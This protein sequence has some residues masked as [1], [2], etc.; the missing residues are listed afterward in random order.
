MCIL[1]SRN[2]LSSARQE[3]DGTHFVSKRSRRGANDDFQSN[4]EESLN[5]LR[6]GGSRRSSRSVEEEG[7]DGKHRQQT[8]E[9]TVLRI[10]RSHKAVEAA[11]VD[12]RS[13]RSTR[14]RFI[15]GESEEKYSDLK[16]MRKQSSDSET[17]S[18]QEGGSDGEHQDDAE[19]ESQNH[20]I[21]TRSTIKR[22][23]SRH[24][25]EKS[26]PAIASTKRRSARVNYTEKGSDDEEESDDETN[27]QTR[28]SVRLK[29]KSASTKRRSSRRNASDSDQEST[30]GQKDSD[31]DEQHDEHDDDRMSSN[32]RSKRVRLT[33]SSQNDSICS[34]NGKENDVAEFSRKRSLSVTS[35]QGSNL[36][37]ASSKHEGGE[38]SRAATRSAMLKTLDYMDEIDAS[39][40]LFAEPVDVEDAPD[41]Y[42][43]IQKPIDRATIRYYKSLNKY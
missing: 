37:V 12:K 38:L 9:A 15:M 4:H 21:S 17:E 32:T 14:I 31:L 43:I 42:E 18:N 28:S 6:T 36:L 19:N 34:T 7:E 8:E 25:N 41:Y 35:S 29:S 13:S 5:L 30:N 22:T 26:L 3:V 11:D 27:A 40:G 33:L 20:R 1:L 23:A 2:F 10:T 39:A 16:D 24:S